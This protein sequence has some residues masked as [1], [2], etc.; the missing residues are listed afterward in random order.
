MVGGENNIPLARLNGPEVQLLVTNP[1]VNYVIAVV[2]NHVTVRGLGV[3]GAGGG[4]DVYYAD[5]NGSNNDFALV[6]QNVLGASAADFMH[7]GTERNQENLHL[8]T[9]STGAIV[10]CNLMKDAGDMNLH[11]ANSTFGDLV[12]GNEFHSTVGYPS[13]PDLQTGGAGIRMEGASQ[14]TIKGNLFFGAQ[15]GGIQLLTGSGGTGCT[16]NVI[17]DNT[18]TENS[19]GGVVVTSGNSQVPAAISQANK[20]SRNSFYKNGGLAIDL[21]PLPLNG[22]YAPQ[23]F[24]TPN[25]GL[26][27]NLMPNQGVDYPVF[28]S[29][30]LSGSTL[31]VQGYVGNTSVGPFNNTTVEVYVADNIPADQNGA[32][33]SGDG[34][35]V[36]HGE[37]RYYIGACVTDPNS[38]FNCSLPVPTGVTITV[39]T[40]QITATATRVL[41]TSEFGPNK[42]VECPLRITKSISNT[43]VTDTQDP[44]VTIGETVVFK[45]KVELPE[46]VSPSLI[47]SDVI[48]PGMSVVSINGV[49]TD[50][51]SIPSGSIPAPTITPASVACPNVGGT[52][53]T[54]SYGSINVPVDGNPN[55]NYFCIYIVA[56][57]CDTSANMGM[58]AYNQT[59]LANQATAVIGPQ[60]SMCAATSNEVVLKVVEPKV[61]IRKRFEPAFVKEGDMTMIKLDVTNTGLSTAYSVIIQD[62]IPLWLFDNSS[63]MTCGSVPTGFTFTK[64]VVGTNSVVTFTGGNIAPG[65]TFNFCFKGT[66]K[67]H[68]Q[69]DTFVNTAKIIQAWTLPPSDCPP[70]CTRPT[71][72]TSVQGRDESGFF[73]NATLTILPAMDCACFGVNGQNGIQPPAYNDMVLWLK[74]DE[75]TGDFANDSSTYNNDGTLRPAF[76]NGPMHGPN[77]VQGSLIFDGLNDYV[78]V[79]DNSTLDM[80]TGSLTIDVWLRPEPESVAFNSGVR[81][82]VDKRTFVGDALR[83]S[84]GGIPATFVYGYQ[85]YLFN[86]YL[87]LQLDSGSDQQKYQ[88]TANPIPAGTWTHVT[89]VA[90]RTGN[91]PG[92]RLYVN[93]TMVQH[94]I[95]P[96]VT[97]NLDNDSQ[98][99]VGRSVPVEGNFFTGKIDELE[100]FRIELDEIN[101]VLDESLIDGIVNAGSYG[102]CLPAP[103]VECCGTKPNYPDVPGAPDATYSTF[104]GQVVL[105]T[106]YT[107]N[108][109]GPVVAA[110]DLKNQSGAPIDSN[111]FSNSTPPTAF[112][113]HPNWNMGRLGDVFGLTLDNAGNVYVA[114]SSIYFST[115]AGIGPQDAHKGTA[116]PGG[117]YKILNGAAVTDFVTT[118][119]ATVFTTGD[120]QLPNFDP[121]GP[122]TGTPGA[123]T[124]APG[125]GNLTYDC[126]RDMLYV[127]NFEDGRIYRINAAGVIQ[128]YWD[129][130]ENLSSPVFDDGLQGM[131]QTARRVFAVKT[132]NN[133]LYYSV[134]KTDTY[135]QNG[136]T[137]NEVWSVPLTSSG[138]TPT[139]KL[140]IIVP[141]LSGFSYSNPVSDISFTPNGTMLLA[142]R[143]MWGD[144]N[145][146]ATQKGSY[147]HKSRV[148][149]YVPSGLHWVPSA[150]IFEVG[151]PQLQANAS[152]GVDSDRGA[153]GRYWATGD[154][155]HYNF[156][157]LG[158]PLNDLIYGLQGMP[159]NGTGLGANTTTSILIDLDNDIVVRDKTQI[160]DVQIPC[161]TD[162]CVN[163]N[164]T[165]GPNNEL[166]SGIG[167]QNYTSPQFTATGGTPGYSFTATNLPLGLTMSPNGVISG[168][169]METGEKLITVKV[170]DANG[171]MATTVYTLGI[172]CA[173][174]LA[175][176]PNTVPNGMVGMSYSQNFAASGGCG[177]PFTYAITAGTLPAGLSLNPTTGVL[178][179][180]PTTCC[181]FRFTITATD[182]CGCSVQ[183]MYVLIIE[184]SPAMITGLYNTGVNNIGGLLADGAI[185]SHY[186][187][188]RPGPA[189]DFAKV[190]APPIFGVPWL[191][192]GPN[193]K[194]IGP[195]NVA[196]G[197][198]IYRTTFDLPACL[199]LSARIE[200]S[201]GTDDTA[202]MYL[203]PD[204]NFTV[205]P[206][207]SLPNNV[208]T[209]YTQLTP[210]SIT[211]GFR[212]GTNE[213]IIKVIKSP[214]P[215]AKPTGL[216]IEWNSAIYKCC[217]CLLA[218]GPDTLPN[219]VIGQNYDQALEVFGGTPAYTFMQTGGT[220]PPGVTF[221]NGVFSGTPT[222][223]GTYNV[224]IKV[225]D[226]NGCM[227]TRIITIVIGCPALQVA[228]RTLPAGLVGVTY[229]QA[230]SV[231]GSTG[232]VTW[233]IAAGN[234]PPGVMLSPTGTLLGTPTAAGL[235]NVTLRGADATT[236]A[237]TQE[238]S[239]E[240]LCPHINIFP[241]STFPAAQVGQS[242]NATFTASGGAAPYTFT[243]VTGLLPPGL[244]LATTG[245]LSSTP[246]T[247]GT[248]NF[249]IQAAS[250]NGCV[251]T[252][253]VSLTV[254]ADIV[255]SPANPVLPVARVGQ[256]YNQFFN[257]TGSIG[258]PIWRLG[259]GSVPPGLSL[260]E[261]SGLLSG[262]PIQMG[263]FNF[264][265]SATDENGCPGSQAYTLTVVDCNASP[266]AVN[267]AAMANG[268][269]G[270]AYSQTLVATG[271]TP[272]RTFTI[273]AG[274]APN[275]L[276]LSTT[277]L[278]SGV[279]TAEGT[280][281]FT[282]QA[283]DANGCTG[284]RAYTVIIGG[285][286]LMFYPLDAP[287]RALET[288][289]GLPV[290][291]VRPNA[292]IAAGTTFTLGVLSTCTGIPATARAVLGN[293]TVVPGPVGGYLT[294]FPSNATQPTVANSNFKPL[295]ITNNVFT[296]GLGPADGAFKIFASAT[297][298]VIVDIT[299]YFAPPQ[300]NGLYFH[301][302]NEPVRLVETRTIPG[303]PGCIK[304]GAPFPTG[305]TEVQGRSPVA[306]PCNA[307]PASARAIIGNVTTIFPPSGGFLTI[308]PSDAVQPTMA[309][310]NYAGADV[311]NGPFT[312]KLGADGKFKVFTSIATDLV[313]DILGYYSTEAIDANGTGLL[314]TPLPKPIRELETRPDFPG[315][316]LT[317]CVRTNAPI[318]GGTGGIY[319]QPIWGTCDGITIPN[320]ARAVLGNIT[321]VIGSSGGLSTGYLTGYPGDV[322]AAPTVATSN[323]PIP[324][325]FG[326]NRFFATGL[327]PTNGTFKIF[328][329]AT[330]EVIVDVSGYFAP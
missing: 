255:I 4:Y 167:G 210:F 91:N 292:P 176:A 309:A 274:V 212:A 20:I 234:L 322:A 104:T 116:G 38:L 86:G 306:S 200:G 320:V 155:L 225:T 252:L 129:H 77:L 93:G 74:F 185:D 122:G 166:P 310:S 138:F 206:V 170:T 163:A 226:A 298:E 125:L 83:P 55:N 121:L 33:L 135:R 152:G 300:A 189:L 29:A 160:G 103:P 326:Y 172:E 238:Y 145:F 302:L 169:A 130:G 173:T 134:W 315:F 284:T 280:Y 330:T 27:N 79:P 319:T 137:H 203:N 57:V 321:V 214:D 259:S 95:A 59:M 148:L 10:R 81:T 188:T 165:I 2:G 43:S 115:V 140:E 44:E 174:D 72:A 158:N 99:Y 301:P 236:C 304:P 131:T 307:I 123:L 15:R 47:V 205:A 28:T 168:V 139:P 260:N 233:S 23:E 231:T 110:V 186:T 9:G 299:G 8:T 68:C 276:T 243:R 222:M 257:Q 109:N 78:E 61:I 107:P 201:W 84:G 224:T 17:Q 124:L 120:S 251:G 314:F 108:I 202:V 220:L 133:Q 21:N 6:E 87:S 75:G 144:L 209:N 216:R 325:T 156:I 54:L 246:T 71:S 65:Q 67:R 193:S 177:G 19:I 26:L 106:C 195:A 285:N 266:I 5:F 329:S 192:N 278:L 153:N 213:L 269:V 221:T 42:V 69:N 157:N 207:A 281:N 183:Q 94:A 32:I 127:S 14:H 161:P 136:V 36:P 305:T 118:K 98:L 239:F 290:G 142:E 31:A 277:G 73:G 235:Y 151:K 48:P 194:W 146:N 296:V 162:P 323:Y 291:C 52:P 283:T 270:T 178:S 316:P 219:G 268:F 328:T 89:A 117:I 66:V 196:D 227:V 279:P 286:G 13:N 245:V 258:L 12:E 267:P 41:D 164:I 187:L 114:A 308:W 312:V 228:P 197:E 62:L 265:V 30:T 119:Q 272:P 303:L 171:C 92:V 149:E 3:Q 240:V 147:A 204:A 199:S 45:L 85:L 250:A 102:K 113:H 181:D 96:L 232:S 50:G 256:A 143:T 317:G 217:P 327:S 97:G 264:A 40:T 35:N 275:G 237:A 34:Q 262:T 223:P 25:D 51:G 159:V 22:I 56:T 53:I 179:G 215:A 288:R 261:F 49:V 80:G 249:T 293:I 229:S 318:A 198:Y 101:G 111:W 154:A 150:K 287:V 282:V 248:F 241:P 254:C 273:N 11:L 211:S 244:T 184:G 313:I 289:V 190:L 297:T 64:N 126:A 16:N 141:F 24:V 180:T 182:K 60:P 105:V 1:A 7:I 230:L 76:P 112:Y 324:A 46:G 63:I 90:D 253:Q 311:V 37:G 128:D 263:T 208:S 88:A 100:I 242:F 70:N 191:A 18:F 58:F 271:G 294:L 132:Y 39:G 295:E 218:L 175:I 82:I 247:P